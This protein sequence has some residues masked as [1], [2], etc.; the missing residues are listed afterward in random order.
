[1]IFTILGALSILAAVVFLIMFFMFLIF[2]PSSAVNYLIYVIAFVINGI[3]F[4]TLSKMKKDIEET[5]K[6]LE[7]QDKLNNSY[8]N[9]IN[10][11]ETK[12]IKLKQKF[13]KKD[14]E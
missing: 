8:N 12:I 9:E 1:M 4:F 14:G 5:K 7:K 10:N 13:E 3:V 6:L 11:L 2:N